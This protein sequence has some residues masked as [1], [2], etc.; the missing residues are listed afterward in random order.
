[1]L[2]TW[3][4]WE[5]CLTIAQIIMWISRHAWVSWGANL[6][7][8][9]VSFC[10][11]LTASFSARTWDQSLKLIASCTVFSRQRMNTL[12]TILAPFRNKGAGMC[13]DY[14]CRMRF[15]R[16]CISSMLSGFS[17]RDN[18]YEQGFVNKIKKVLAPIT[19]FIHNQ[20]PGMLH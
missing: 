12:T 16:R 9:G 3:G 14:T 7:P 19:R 10:T 8:R 13:M 15:W 4:G 6:I 5:L 20:K 1:M 2:R 11:T 18:P 17:T